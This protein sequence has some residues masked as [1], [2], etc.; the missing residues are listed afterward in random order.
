MKLT[1]RLILVPLLMFSL[2]ASGSA[3]EKPAAKEPSAAPAKK[4][5]TQTAKKSK[6]PASR[7]FT[8]NITAIDTKTGVVSVKGTIEEKNF[9]TQDASKDA[10]ERLAIGDRVR[11]LY[12]EKD[13]KALASS[14]RRLKLPQSKPKTSEQS[15]KSKTSE[16]KTDSKEKAKSGT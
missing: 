7:K 10:L 15:A 14:V 6:K 12:S 5:A 1:L 16:R 3:A 13:G 11:V 2:A 4:P 9:M 8:G